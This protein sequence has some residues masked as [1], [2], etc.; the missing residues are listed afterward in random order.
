MSRANNTGDPSPPEP[1]LSAAE[2]RLGINSRDVV[3]QYPRG[4]LRAYV[5]AK[6]ATDPV[7]AAVFERLRDSKQPVMDIG[8]GIGLLATYLRSRGFEAPIAGIDHDARKIR[9]AQQFASHANTSFAV[10]DARASF[11]F[12]G[13]VVLL[14]VLHYFSDDDQRAILRNAAGA[15]GMILIRDGVRDGSLRYRATYAQETIAR[16]GGW[17]KAERLNFPTRQSIEQSF[18]GA[19]STE[20][21]PMFGRSPFNN[22]LFV[23][24]RSSDGITNV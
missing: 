12:R 13:N 3:A 10:G 15:G 19:L 16:I 8:C 24:R 6:V 14:D 17:L 21:V 2:G 18:N 9:I 4:F 23:F 5:R 1:G 7:Y 11:D 22:Y 20:V